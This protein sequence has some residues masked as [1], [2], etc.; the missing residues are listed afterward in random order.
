[1]LTAKL[2][3]QVY[4]YHKLRKAISKFYRTLRVDYLIQILTIMFWKLL[5]QGLSKQ[6]I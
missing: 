5:Q 4:R 2:L 1:M 3:E 6:G